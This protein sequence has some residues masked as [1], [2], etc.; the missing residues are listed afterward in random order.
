MGT[1]LAG[2]ASW[3]FAAPPAVERPAVE[4]PVADL[5]SVELP[6]AKL[7]E[8]QR[9]RAAA[10]ASYATGKSL[11]GQGDL[12]GALRYYQRAWRWDPTQSSL[13]DEIVPLAVSVGQVDTAIR[14]ALVQAEQGRAAP[15]MLRRLALYASQQQDWSQAARLYRL[16]L[17]E[18]PPEQSAFGRA[19]VHIELGRL[20][21]L[22]GNIPAASAVFEEAQRAMLANPDSELARRLAAALGGSLVKTLETFGRCHLEAGNL[23]LAAQAFGALAECPG[24]QQESHYW[25]SRLALEQSQ[26]LESYA[27]LGGYFDGPQEPLGALPYDAL[28][29]TLVRLNDTERLGAD[30][31]RLRASHPHSAYARLAAAQSLVAEGETAVAE[32]LLREL[33]ALASDDAADPIDQETFAEAGNWLV[34]HA[35]AADQPNSLLPLLAELVPHD[36]TLSLFEDSLQQALEDKR[37]KEQMVA[38][39]E[40]PSETKA[41]SFEQS[42]AAGRLSLLAEHYDLAFDYFTKALLAKSL[43]DAKQTDGPHAAAELA[44]DWAVEL[45]LAEQY[46][47]AT[48][49]IRWGLDQGILNEQHPTAWFYLGTAMAL[50]DEV[51]PALEAARRAAQLDPESVEFAARPAWVLY[52]AE[53]IEDAIK[54]YQQL[55]KEFGEENDPATREVLREARLTLSYLLLSKD[56]PAGSAE[57]IE[58]V[59]DEFPTDLGAMNDLGFLWAQQGEH[60]ERARRMLQQVVQGEPENPAYLDSLGWAQFRLGEQQAALDTI[61]KA[62]QIQEKNGDPPEAEIL[63]H[64]GDVLHSLGR[65]QAAAQAWRRALEQLEDKPENKPLRSKINNKLADTPGTEDS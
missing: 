26:P 60:L 17:D 59:L 19:L 20:E 1:L 57:Q 22:S 2:A 5:P 13:L 35:A 3:S 31:E 18:T 61:N 27:H 44:L 62:L 45:L 42:L 40:M 37:F 52:R 28:R 38:R 30:L 14:Y 23:T 51:E 15:D 4:R 10:A 6:V 7:T 54:E 48:R 41:P 55:I 43:D 64:L 24:T 36:P 56:D 39:L 50:Q 34:A 46:A 21:Y 58:Q 47:Q 65:Q 49:A 12:P 32:T 25:A 33:V 29:E 16:W 8:A 9:D 53:R 63:D 11:F